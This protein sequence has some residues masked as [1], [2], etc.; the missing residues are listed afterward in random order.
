MGTDDLLYKPQTPRA[1]TSSCCRAGPGRPGTAARTR[2]GKSAEPSWP[3]APN[4]P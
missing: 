4:S 1:G 3:N 2:P